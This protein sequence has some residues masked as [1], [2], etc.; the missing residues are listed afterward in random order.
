[1]RRSLW[2][3]NVKR[4]EKCLRFPWSWKGS[5]YK[6]DNFYLSPQNMG[7]FQKGG[8]FLL[9]V[10]PL[11]KI[12]E[13]HDF[14][15]Q[16]VLS[17]TIDTYENLYE[18]ANEHLY[19]TKFCIAFQDDTSYDVFQ[20]LLDKT[21]LEC[22]ANPFHTSPEA[23]RD[24]MANVHDFFRCETCCSKIEVIPAISSRNHSWLYTIMGKTGQLPTHPLFWGVPAQST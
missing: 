21:C 17:T 5:F 4:I 2:V 10:A 15:L 1:M 23:L 12:L 11:L 20:S 18:K 19:I 3:F 6:A 13:Y 16:V 9:F 8:N 24:H 7:H 14:L 22:P